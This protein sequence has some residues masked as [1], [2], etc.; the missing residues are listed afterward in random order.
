[1]N[2]RLLSRN[3][4]HNVFSELEG[5]LDWSNIDKTVSVDFDGK[6]FLAHPTT[7]KC[8]VWD[9]TLTPYYNSG[10][11]ES[12]AKRL[13]WYLF[14]NFYVDAFIPQ[15]KELIYI[16]SNSNFAGSLIKLN[17][18]FADLDFNLDGQAD[19]INAF[20]MTPFIQFNAVAYLK[21]VKNIYVQCRGDTSSIIDMYYYTEESTVP[22]HETDSIRIG[23]RLWNR[24]QYDNFQWL[25]VNWANTFRRKCS[26]KKIQMASFYF[27]NKDKYVL[28]GETLENVSIDGA[29]DD[30]DGITPT[31]GHYYFVDGSFYLYKDSEYNEIEYISVADRDMSISH[32][33][34]QY[35]I[36]KNIK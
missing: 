32:I 16:S 35:S 28:D 18:G 31:S 21:N 6:Y 30:F 25:M 5:L 29:Y 13:E 36:V 22:E 17:E 23:G 7:G 14:D 8:Y 27:E 1:M 12:D 11:V 3:I 34:L 19:G 4:D 2:V 20:Y 26:L 10:R 24:F 33:A 15:A 9:Y